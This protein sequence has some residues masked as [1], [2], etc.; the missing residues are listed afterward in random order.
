MSL[1]EALPRVALLRHKVSQE[2]SEA[3]EL[4]TRMFLNTAVQDIARAEKTTLETNSFMLNNN[5][6]YQTLSDGEQG[7]LDSLKFAAEVDKDYYCNIVNLQKNWQAMSEADHPI[8]SE[9]LI[10]RCQEAVEAFYKQSNSLREKADLTMLKPETTT[11]TTLPFT[12][13][14]IMEL[15]LIFDMYLLVAQELVKRGLSGT[16]EDVRLV[17]AEL[18][19]S[20]GDGDMFPLD[21]FL[22][23]QSAPLEWQQQFLAEVTPTLDA[24]TGTISSKNENLPEEALKQIRAELMKLT[25]NDFLTIKADE[26][27]TEEKP[28]PVQG[29]IPE[30]LLAVRNDSTARDYPYKHIPEYV[31]LKNAC[32][33]QMESWDGAGDYW[34]KWAL[35]QTALSTAFKEEDPTS[36]NEKW[37]QYISPAPG[38]PALD[39]TLALY[40]HFH[41]RY[42]A[43]YWVVP[44]RALALCLS[45]ERDLQKLETML[46]DKALFQDRYQNSPHE[47]IQFLTQKFHEL[48]GCF[49]VYYEFIQKRVDD[50]REPYTML[51]NPF[52]ALY[53]A[54]KLLKPAQFLQLMDEILLAKKKLVERKV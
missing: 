49:D 25:F 30:A 50:S 19:N 37:S 28:T 52:V 20:L 17:S 54:Q 2:A 44:F 35:F 5:H 53:L 4:G 22:F 32:F 1:L 9:W 12:M 48:Q 6:A 8:V 39:N 41:L 33:E 26:L 47:Y 21:V 15:R 7:L 42:T 23:F 10:P 13:T 18:R 46:P 45:T 14:K 51:G 24:L 27:F 34:E 29:P 31:A 43:K 40:I 11:N 36:F 38:K 16:L 3:L